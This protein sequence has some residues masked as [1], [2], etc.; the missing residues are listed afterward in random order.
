MN[1]RHKELYS[2]HRD[3]AMTTTATPVFRCQEKDIEM[4]RTDNA[5]TPFTSQFSGQDITTVCCDG[6]LCWTAKDI[7]RALGYGN[8][9]SCFTKRIA[10]DWCG[11]FIEGHDFA[12]IQGETLV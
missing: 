7:G 1:L 5:L 6:R 12:V 4:Q 11:E 10:A 9:G 8:E 3:L 2:G